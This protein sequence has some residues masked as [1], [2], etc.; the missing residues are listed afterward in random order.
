MSQ[1]HNPAAFL[2]AE[3]PGSKTAKLIILNQPIANGTVL[4]R[5]WCCSNYHLCADGGANRLQDFVSNNFSPEKHDLFLPQLLHGDLDSVRDDSLIYYSSKGVTISKD[6]DQ[7]STDF[8]K[9]IA[10]IRS[11]SASDQSPIKDVLILGSISGR[12]DQGLGLLHEIYREHVRNPGLRLWLF[13]EC[14]VS[15]LLKA[16]RNVIKTCAVAKKGVKRA[17]GK[18]F[19][20]NVGILPIF[21]AATITTQGLEW[22]V[23]D[24]D[25]S[26]G[27]NVSTSNH[28]VADEVSVETSAV[29]LFTI[30]MNL[31][32]LG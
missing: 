24:W 15:F 9:A 4:E 30:E 20:Q 3:E 28:V 26:M 11:S 14:S 12:V 2:Q 5:I 7:Y 21:G 29:V 27:G 22:D 16:G 6:E 31:D 25:T 17:Q 1:E 13:S 8:G 19:T 32:Q 23:Q 10:K 18:L